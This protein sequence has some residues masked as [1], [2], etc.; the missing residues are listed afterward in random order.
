MSISTWAATSG[1]WDDAKFSRAWNGPYINPAVASLALTGYAPT[2]STEFNISV[3][4]AS[5]ELIQTYDWENVP[6]TWSAADWNWDQSPVVPGISVGTVITPDG[7]NLIFTSSIPSV[8]E[9]HHTVI[10]VASLALTGYAPTELA[11]RLFYPGAASLTGL[12]L[13]TTWATDT[14][15]WATVSGNWDTGTI[16]PLVGVTYTFIIDSAGNLILTPYDPEYP[17]ERQPKFIPP[18]LIS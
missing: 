3:G 4:N 13:G 16:A 2:D 10:P 12:N 8:D 15:T 7:V 14:S 18:I 1:D 6:G 17:I 5:L 11:G 9:I